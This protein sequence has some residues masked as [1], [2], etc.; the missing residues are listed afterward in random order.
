MSHDRGCYCGKEA[1]EYHDCDY[2]DCVKKPK[3][4]T[5]ETIL[6]RGTVSGRTSATATALSNATRTS[7]YGS[8]WADAAERAE[9]AF[10]A[11]ALSEAI[12]MLP[13]HVSWI[14][15]AQQ[16]ATER[17]KTG[18]RNYDSN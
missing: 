10:M 12:K 8:T 4:E 9:W 7:K 5:V 1:Y 18:W 14:A 2:S 3:L 16:L 11:T 15:T 6:A 13:Q 17:S